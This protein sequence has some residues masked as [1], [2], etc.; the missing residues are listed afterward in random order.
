MAIFATR[1]MTFSVR[2]GY[3]GTQFIGKM[4]QGVTY[5]QT[6]TTGKGT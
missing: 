3:L 5:Q 6:A 1:A 4:K 2:A